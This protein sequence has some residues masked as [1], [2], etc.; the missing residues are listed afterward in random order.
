MVTD[1]H[2]D[3]HLVLSGGPDVVRGCQPPDGG[4]LGRLRQVGWLRGAVALAVHRADQDDAVA[5]VGG[6]VLLEILHVVEVA[7]HEG[8]VRGQLRHDAGLGV[9]E[10]DKVGRG[11]AALPPARVDLQPGG[12]RNSRK[13]KKEGK[14]RLS[15][16][17]A[18]V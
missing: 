5:P 1:H 16:S 9:D 3:R 14:K 11:V 6:Q 2:T 15:M 17:A 8:A 12:L 18:P 10:R 4:V 7:E 13:G